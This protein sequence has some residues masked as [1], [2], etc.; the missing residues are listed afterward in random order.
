MIF[1]EDHLLLLYSY[2]KQYNISVWLYKMLLNARVFFGGGVKNLF[3]SKNPRIIA[4]E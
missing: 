1:L 4:T 3:L 2:F